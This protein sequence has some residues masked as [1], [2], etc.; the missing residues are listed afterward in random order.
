MIAS[1]CCKERFAGSFLF[2][3]FERNLIPYSTTSEVIFEDQDGNLFTAVTEGVEVTREVQ[4]NCA[5]CCEDIETES[6]MNDLRFINQ[7][8]E[9][10]IFLNTTE[11]STEFRIT[12]REIN[13]A[14][15]MVTLQDWVQTPDNNIEL[16]NQKTDYSGYGFDFSDVIILGDTNDGCNNQKLKTIVFSE[17]NGIELLGFMD[18]S[19]LRLVN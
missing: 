17:T 11:F 19:Y 16:E 8:M 18:D 10:T 3:D 12:Y 13:E 7:R 1:G 4:D 15:D 6:I 5:D 14:G 9:L 2:T